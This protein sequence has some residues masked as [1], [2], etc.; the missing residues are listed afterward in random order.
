MRTIIK[1]NK[2]I[3]CQKKN[4]L[5]RICR[6]DRVQIKKFQRLWIGR[7]GNNQNVNHH[8]HDIKNRIVVIKS[9]QLHIV[10]VTTMIEN[11]IRINRE[12]NILG[13]I[14]KN[15]TE[16]HLQFHLIDLKLNRGEKM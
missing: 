12:D 7:I 8:H 13:M 2:L 16:A 15:V 6:Q 9:N 10:R 4:N 14:R 1:Y 5:K 11:L 3:I